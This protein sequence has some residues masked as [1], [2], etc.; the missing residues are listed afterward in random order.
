[1]K[2]GKRSYHDIENINY[3]AHNSMTTTDSLYL[4]SLL[5]LGSC[6]EEIPVPSIFTI[7]NVKDMANDGFF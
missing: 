2:K 6:F 4:W 3:F 5:R 7:Q 1:M